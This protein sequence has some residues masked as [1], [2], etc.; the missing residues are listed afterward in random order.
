MESVSETSEL[1]ILHGVDTHLSRGEQNGFGG[2][3]CDVTL[4]RRG[5]KIAY[6]VP[7]RVFS[8]HALTERKRAGAVSRASSE[9]VPH[10][11]QTALHLRTDNSTT[12]P[13]CGL[14]DRQI[15]FYGRPDVPQWA[16]LLSAF[17]SAFPRPVQTRTILRFSSLPPNKCHG[18]LHFILH[19]ASGVTE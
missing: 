1:I 9:A 3:A 14:P 4:C 8:L 2:V 7:Q 16:S 12:E 5:K 17:M 19:K 13:L 10:R 11:G 15:C 18:P 6:D